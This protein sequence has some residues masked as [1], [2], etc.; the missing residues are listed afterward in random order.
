[1]I[2]VGI[3]TEKIDL[4]EYDAIS[5]DQEYNQNGKFYMGRYTIYWSLDLMSET[6]T[7]DVTNRPDLGIRVID[8][9]NPTAEFRIDSPLYKKLYA[10]LSADFN[11]KQLSV[12]GDVTIGNPR[13]GWRNRK[14]ENVIIATW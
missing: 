9:S 7:L 1:M 4:S 14:Y 3:K 8:K 10:E 11:S 5:D 13:T 2:F 12:S 6:I